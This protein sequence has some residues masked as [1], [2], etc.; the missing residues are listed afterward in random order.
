MICVACWVK[1]RGA[2]MKEAAAV[3]KGETVCS[4]HLQERAE[5]LE[6]VANAPDV[7]PH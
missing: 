2:E 7:T 3:F 1:S 5:G 6:N 4:E